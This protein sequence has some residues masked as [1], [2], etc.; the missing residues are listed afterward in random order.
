[1]SKECPML[2]IG[3]TVVSNYMENG[4]KDEAEHGIHL[5]DLESSMSINWLKNKPAGSVVYVSFGSWINLSVE[6]MEELALGL[7]NSNFYFIWVVRPSEEEKLPHRFVEEIIDKGLVVN[8]SPQLEIISNE[9]IGCFI[10]HCGWNSITE[11][12]SFE[13]AMVGMPQWSDQFTN[14]KLIEDL[15]KVGVRVKVAENGI[16]KREEIEFCIREVMKGE[17]RRQIKSNAKKWKAVVI[18][19]ISKDGSSD[20]NIDEFVS[21]LSKS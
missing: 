2:T 17:K 9:A 20:K 8:W 1:M 13:V 21:R 4:I 7:K 19:A 12:L 16:V 14:A 15:W 3:P 18:K 10:T 11:A 5:Y 6:Q